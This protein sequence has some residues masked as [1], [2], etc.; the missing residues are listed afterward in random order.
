MDSAVV[1]IDVGV[2]G[3]MGL[4]AA[5]GYTAVVDWKTPQL[6]RDTI[7]EW[8]SQ[9]RLELVA[10]EKVNAMPSR[11]RNG[12]RVKM[13]TQSAFNFGRNAGYWMGLLV[14]MSLPIIEVAPQ[15]WQKG[16]VGK[17]KVDGVKPSMA[18]A[19]KLFPTISLYGPK[20]GAKDGRADA[21]LIAHWA[22]GQVGWHIQNEQDE[23]DW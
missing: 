21:M 20:G 5:N 12:Q 7:M 19:A 3:A 13:G 16:L 22:R 23:C 18:V 1:G 11:G 14:G 4:I 17:K 2:K 8:R 9:H 6:M 10:V 15:T